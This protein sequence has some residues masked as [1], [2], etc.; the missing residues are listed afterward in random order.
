M[1]DAHEAS[2]PWKSDTL[3]VVSLVPLLSFRSAAFSV[4]WSTDGHL[5]SDVSFGLP[6]NRAVPVLLGLYSKL[7]QNQKHNQ[8]VQRIQAYQNLPLSRTI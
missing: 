4:P 3:L 1:L 2:K 6:A 7:F 5:L 8:M